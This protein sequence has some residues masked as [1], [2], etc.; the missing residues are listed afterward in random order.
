MFLDSRCCEK[1]FGYLRDFFEDVL[2]R[3]TIVFYLSVTTGYGGPT[4]SDYLQ[5]K[6]NKN[7]DSVV[8]FLVFGVRSSYSDTEHS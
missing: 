1:N 5:K 4:L 2:F 6:R 8:T 3:F 7:E